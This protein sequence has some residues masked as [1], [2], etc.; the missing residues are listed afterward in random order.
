MKMEG[1]SFYSGV[2]NPT[3]HS[4]TYYPSNTSL[5]TAR[6]WIWNRHLE[7]IYDKKN[8][9][10]LALTENSKNLWIVLI[11]SHPPERE[12]NG[13]RFIISWWYLNL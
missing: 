11:I 6:A 9:W 8:Q 5:N 13:K 1:D 10:I 7:L 12:T 4:V 2:T 3:I